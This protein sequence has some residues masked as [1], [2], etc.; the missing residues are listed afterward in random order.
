[1]LRVSVSI[2][3]GKCMLDSKGQVGVGN[4]LR[5]SGENLGGRE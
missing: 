2:V 3:A 1:M 4:R 5:V